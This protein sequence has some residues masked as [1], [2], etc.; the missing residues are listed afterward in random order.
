MIKRQKKKKKALSV[1]LLILVVLLFFFR[2]FI[3]L[4]NTSAFIL[5]PSSSAWPLF[6]WHSS[7]SWAMRMRLGTIVI[8]LRLAQMVGNSYGRVPHEVSEI[9]TGRS[10]TAMMVSLF[11]E[12]WL[13]S[14][15]VGIERSWSW[16]LL[17][18]YGKNNKIQMLGCAYRTFVAEKDDFEGILNVY[19]WDVCVL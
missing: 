4:V 11:N 3:V 7:A 15:Q 17:G 5:K 10:G 6:T 18:G 1:V 19:L 12:T 16:E 14:S 2:S 8:A 9:V 13:S